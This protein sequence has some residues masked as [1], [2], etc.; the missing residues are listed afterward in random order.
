[1]SRTIAVAPV[2]KSVTVNAPSTRAF[3]IFANQMTR[4]W[5]PTHTILKVA[6]RAHVI[7]PR[8][9]GR[10]YSVGVDDSECDVGKVLVWEPPSRLVLVWQLSP[11]WQFDPNLHTEVELRF[12]PDGE[13]TRVEL[14]HRQLERMGERAEAVRAQ[15]DAAGGWS[16][17][18]ER[19]KAAVNG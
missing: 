15:I 16:E 17:I 14:E 8:T 4:W 5:P 3:D 9:G 10:W 7:E 12:I 19:F 18:I 6:P 11:D 1:M 13:K 2:R